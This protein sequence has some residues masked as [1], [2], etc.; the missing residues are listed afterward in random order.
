M[1]WRGV[2]WAAVLYLDVVVWVHTTRFLHARRVMNSAA[3][4]RE[5]WMAR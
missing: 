1:I 2:I 4:R 5:K 3:K